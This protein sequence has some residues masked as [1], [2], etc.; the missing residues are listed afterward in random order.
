LGEPLASVGL[1]EAPSF[2]VVDSV[3][4]VHEAAADFKFTTSRH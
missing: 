3:M 4:T 1:W 2:A